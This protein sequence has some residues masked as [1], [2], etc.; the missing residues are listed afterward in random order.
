M[1]S[2]RGTTTSASTSFPTSPCSTS[3]AGVRPERL[4]MLRTDLAAVPYTHSCARQK[5]WCCRCAKC[6]YVWMNYVAWLPQ[7][8]VSETF[9][10]NLFEIPENRSL[11][12]KML[13]LESY[14]P[15]DC[16][17]T[18]NEARLAFAMCRAKGVGGVIA[19]D[20]DV[21]E[22]SRK[23]QR[24]S[25]DMA[26]GKP[27]ATFPPSLAKRLRNNSRTSRASHKR[28]PAPPSI[29]PRERD[30]SAQRG[31]ARLAH[32]VPFPDPDEVDDQRRD[33][34]HEPRDGP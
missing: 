8:T 22:S 16:A 9:Q 20:I 17:G 32:V 31:C 11:L 4:P 10:V 26:R 30:L 21:D 18:V 13:G 19:D 15:T 28:S 24:H 34:E 27:E 23:P 33:A 1:P 5:P 29:S 3:Y 6:I 7:E 12:R 2:S 14:K 25:I